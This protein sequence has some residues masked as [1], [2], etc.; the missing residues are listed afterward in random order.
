MELQRTSSPV[1]ASGDAPGEES[2]TKAAADPPK[3]AQASLL[4]V[5]GDEKEPVLRAPT[6]QDRPVMPRSPRVVS[7][8][9][10]S[11][12]A[13]G[14]RDHSRPKGRNSPRPPRDDTMEAVIPNDE[15]RR[16]R[17]LEQEFH[18]A[19]LT[20]YRRAKMEAKYSARRFIGM[21][22]DKGGLKTAQYLLDTPDVSAGYTALWERKRLDLTV[23]A[24]ILEKKWW[25]LFTRMQRRTAITRLRDY[26]YDR[27][28]PISTLS[29]ID[30]FASGSWCAS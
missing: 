22:E 18:E 6:S 5:A 28:F 2:Q 15:E 30:H 12:E 1:Q 24:V 27:R 13:T 4:T 16:R 7:P 11:T 23:E 8:G 25:P 20:V 17:Q 14:L 19:M 3:T 21:V 29:E 10:T 9:G 26:R